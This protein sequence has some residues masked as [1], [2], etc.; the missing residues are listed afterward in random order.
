MHPAVFFFF[1]FFFFITQQI[2]PSCVLNHSIFSRNTC[3]ISFRCAQSSCL[4]SSTCATFCLNVRAYTIFWSTKSTFFTPSWLL[5]FFEDK[6][7]QL[8]MLVWSGV[9]CFRAPMQHFVFAC[10]AIQFLSMRLCYVLYSCVRVSM[11]SNVQI[12]RECFVLDPCCCWLSSLGTGILSITFA[13]TLHFW[14][15]PNL[16]EHTSNA[17]RL[18]EWSESAT[19]CFPAFE[20]LGCLF[21]AP[22][23]HQL[24]FPV[25]LSTSATF[26]FPV[27]E[28]PVF[29]R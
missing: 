28:Y 5:S 8:F 12:T 1:C 16:V 25:S 22:V 21:E 15:Q 9:L 14:T 4:F 6:S 20:H 24:V 18:T 7:K 11:R 26:S 23:Q 19:F 17:S 2:S 29:S 10:S 27:L 13:V 3:N